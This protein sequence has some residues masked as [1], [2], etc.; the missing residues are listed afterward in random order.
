MTYFF[1]CSPCKNEVS[2]LSDLYGTSS[3]CTTCNFWSK[4][5]FI[6]HVTTVFLTCVHFLMYFESPSQCK[7]LSTLITFVWLLSCVSSEMPVEICSL[8][9]WLLAHFTHVFCIYSMYSKMYLQAL[10]LSKC[11]ITY[12][13]LVWLLFCVCPNLSYYK[14]TWKNQSRKMWLVRCSSRKQ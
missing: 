2:Y 1:K 14:L 3:V 7:L 5:F 11:F 13:T 10:S 6:L 9:E 4:E 12:I 8:H